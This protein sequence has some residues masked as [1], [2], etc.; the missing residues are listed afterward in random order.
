[1]KKRTLK[2]RILALAA[3]LAALMSA[4]ILPA[5]AEITWASYESLN[6][7]PPLYNNKTESGVTFTV[8]EDGRVQVKGT[9][10]AT[11][12]YTRGDVTLQNGSTYSLSGT[13]KYTG[14]NNARLQIH[15]PTVNTQYIHYAYQDGVTFT[16]DEGSEITEVVCRIFIV[17]QKGTTVD[18]TFAPTLT[19]SEKV[20]PF[21]PYI[22]N[23]LNA[24]HKAG[25]T[26]GEA[27][28][29]NTGYEA[30][31]VKG[32]NDLKAELENKK[33][34]VFTQGRLIA[35]FD[36][37]TGED[38][39][40]RYT[41]IKGIPYTYSDGTISF[42]SC[43]DYAIS[44]A[45]ESEDAGII[46]SSIEN[47]VW[48]FEFTNPWTYDEGAITTN[49]FN[50]NNIF[51]APTYTFNQDWGNEEID[52]STKITSSGMYAILPQI[53][54]DQTYADVSVKNITIWQYTNASV[55][56]CHPRDLILS[57]QA[58]Y[59]NE[60]YNLGY[61]QGYVAGATEETEEAK[62]IGYAEGEKAGFL[63][64]KEEGL[65]IAENGSW[66][67][68]ATA[69]T[70]APITSLMGLLNFKI[71]GL[72]MQQAFGAMIANCILLIIIKKVLL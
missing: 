69:V 66:I 18:L 29:Y 13:P 44:K 55:A 27:A 70:E 61:T 63:K 7:L 71:L 24:Q 43:Y 64:G 9:A 59:T 38:S 40:I 47:F 5:A 62:A 65:K 11:I 14:T 25:Y 53:K 31:K 56:K 48:R 49:Q 32:Y 51:D 19:K 26:E 68:L 58:R 39:S 28:G 23:W 67:S 60:A 17:I 72:D 8:L 34:N 33:I 42:A 37:Q 6:I 36:Y 57:T 50:D 3:C 46:A 15:I 30:G 12:Y 20:Y 54:S 52:G 4:L 1:M 2:R 21:T 35:S 10:T 16:I 45:Q 22:P 41:E